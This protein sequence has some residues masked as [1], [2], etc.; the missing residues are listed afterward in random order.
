MSAPRLIAVL[1][2]LLTPGAAGADELVQVDRAR[3]QAMSRDEFSA[4]REQLHSRADNLDSAEQRLQREAA[5]TGRSRLDSG[6]G[7]GYGSRGG[8]GGGAGRRR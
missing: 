8:R 7:Q 5:V 2:L 1:A 3:L 4:Y 6:Y